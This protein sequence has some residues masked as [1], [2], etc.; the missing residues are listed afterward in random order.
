M[1]WRRSEKLSPRFLGTV[2]YELEIPSSSKVN[3]IFH[4]CFLY[5]FHGQQAIIPPFSLPLNEDWE[6]PIS[7]TKILAHRWVKEVCSSSLELL[8][9]WLTVCLKKLVGKIM[10]SLQISS[11]LLP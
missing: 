5:Q 2:A 3:L 7:P 10:I 11:L 4:E 8:V 6:L 1:A 9:Q